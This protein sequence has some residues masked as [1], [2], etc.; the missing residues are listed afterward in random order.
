M[1]GVLSA[2]LNVYKRVCH[3]IIIFFFSGTTVCLRTKYEDSIPRGK[4]GVKFMQ[5][6]WFVHFFYVGDYYCPPVSVTSFPFPVLKLILLV[7]LWILGHFLGHWEEHQ[8]EH[9]S[10]SPSSYLQ[11]V[12]GRVNLSSRWC[13]NSGHQSFIILFKSAYLALKKESKW[14]GGNY[15]T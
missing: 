10:P 11:W 2:K 4:C 3:Y 12:T 15:Y 6:K 14:G 13:I 1:S 7:F 8:C 9:F 5:V